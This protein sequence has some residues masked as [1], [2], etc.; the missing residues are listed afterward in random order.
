MA[1]TDATHAPSGTAN[2]SRIRR[3][4]ETKAATKTTEMYAYVA[5]T[6]GVLIAA[7]LTK[8]GDGHDDRFLA[9]HAWLYVTILT[10]AYMISRGLAKSGVREPYTDDGDR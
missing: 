1:A 3:I 6:I 7:A 2:P 4:T 8:A 10:A 9:K 5:A